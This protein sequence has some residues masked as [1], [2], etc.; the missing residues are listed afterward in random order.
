M[1]SK[2]RMASSTTFKRCAAIFAISI[3]SAIA[4]ADDPHPFDG[5]WNTILSCENAAG[6]LGYSF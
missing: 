3:T 5:G 6:A 1:K 4:R 2:F